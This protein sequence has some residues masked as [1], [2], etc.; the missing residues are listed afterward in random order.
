MACVLGCIAPW[1]GQPHAAP[2]SLRQ[3]QGHQK[4]QDHVL[5]A[6]ESM[7]KRPS[8]Q[9]TC[10]IF[11][12]QGR[13]IF[14]RFYLLK[15]APKLQHPHQEG[16]KSLAIPTFHKQASTRVES[17]K[18]PRLTSSPHQLVPNNRINNLIHCVAA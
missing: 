14:L 6:N 17:R 12:V 5:V 7:K 15:Q 2:S 1:L 18:S 4:K 16:C 8:R 10:R 9:S 11:G 13:I 3:V